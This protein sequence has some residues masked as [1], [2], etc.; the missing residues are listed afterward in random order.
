MRIPRT[1]ALTLV[2]G[3]IAAATLI[4]ACSNNDNNGGV[5]TP[6]AKE[7]DSADLAGL[8]AG[9]YSHTFKTIGTYNY[10]CKHHS[11]MHGQVIVLVGAPATA[12]VTISDDKFDASPVTVDTSGT[13]TWTNN[14]G[15]LHTV[16]SD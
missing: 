9:T 6:P 13:V 2:V 3:V 4:A 14:G 8:G 12:S 7:L 10:H 5:L 15:H 11:G 1:I 16:T